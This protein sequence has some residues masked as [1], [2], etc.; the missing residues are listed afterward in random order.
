MEVFYGLI[1]KVL[2]LLKPALPG[3][4]GS[5]LNALI[6]H[7]QKVI[8]GAHF[9]TIKQRLITL[10]AS[11]LIGIGSVYIVL[12]YFAYT[13]LPVQQTVINAVFF[14]SSAGGMETVLWLVGHAVTFVDKLEEH[15]LERIKVKAGERHSKKQSE[16]KE[17]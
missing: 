15:Y 6:T 5:V 10:I 9:L 14:M 17:D 2:L 7:Y 13:G 11:L 8:K 3:L 1:L 4:A 12:A 16:N